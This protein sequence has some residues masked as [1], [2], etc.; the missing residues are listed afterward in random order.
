MK[1]IN[2]WV[3]KQTNSKINNLISEND[4][5]S[6]TRFVL[7]NAI[8]FKSQWS[9]EF[10][11]ELTRAEDFY[12]TETEK[13]KVQMMHGTFNNMSYVENINFKA[14]KLPYKSDDLS[15]TVIL[16]KSHKVELNSQ[17][18]NF[19]FS[20]SASDFKSES[21]QVS[22]PRFKTTFKEDLVPLIKQLGLRLP[23]SD[24]EADFSKLS[25]LA[26][27]EKLHIS[28]VIHQAMIEV[29]EFGSEAAAA[30]AVV[31]EL[32]S[33]YQEPQKPKIFKANQ[34][35]IYLIKKGEQILFVGYFK[36]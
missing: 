29:N 24:S 9:E 26:L 1:N 28:K 22:L 33:V 35:F 2:S 12:M 25:S 19:V 27:S 30:T 4:L 11:E 17:F 15:M 8:Y 16:P 18:L 31:M 32:G 6:A 10:S 14:I 13:V 7:V 23:F 36:G 20:L 34:P 3:S 5:T 21:V